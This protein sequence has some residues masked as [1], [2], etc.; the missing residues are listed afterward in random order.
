M[1]SFKKSRQNLI[2]I[3]FTCTL[4]SLMYSCRYIYDGSIMRQIR[5][6][7]LLTVSY[8]EVQPIFSHR[9]VFLRIKLPLSHFHSFSLS[10]FHSL[11]LSLSH[12]F[13]LSLLNSLTRSL[14]Q[15][16]TISLSNSHLLSLSHYLAHT[17]L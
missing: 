10:L 7:N 15:S 2:L 4:C 13:T 16:L 5:E 14:S 1:N 3:S 9:I 11:T 6:R 12:S 17:H 8:S